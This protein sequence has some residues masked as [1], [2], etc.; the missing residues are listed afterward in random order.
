MNKHSPCSSKISSNKENQVCKSK[1]R[2]TNTNLS[3]SLLN[4]KRNRKNSTPFCEIC[5]SHDFNE[6]SKKDYFQCRLCKSAA[7]FICCNSV[8]PSSY[9]YSSNLCLVCYDFEIK[10]VVF[11]RECSLCYHNQGL[12]LKSTNNYWI[13]PICLY[14]S[15]SHFCDFKDKNKFSFVEIMFSNIDTCQVCGSEKG[16]LNSNQIHPYC[17]FRLGVD[18]NLFY[19][20]ILVQSRNNQKIERNLK[21]SKFEMRNMKVKYNYDFI[22]EDIDDSFKSDKTMSK[23]K[24]KRENNNLNVTKK[25]IVSNF[26]NDNDNDYSKSS[27]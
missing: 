10:K 8:F 12:L 20:N 22:N 15:Y 19:K 16:Y 13:H 5:L 1:T 7:H 3:L 23:S 2:K 9:D 14:S 4:K 6:K 21:I 18:Y 24:S 25:M 27:C 26:I 17:N 11:N